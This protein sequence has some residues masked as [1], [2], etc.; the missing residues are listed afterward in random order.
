[1]ALPSQVMLH[2]LPVVVRLPVSE[3]PWQCFLSFND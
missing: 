2:A 1:L 3:R